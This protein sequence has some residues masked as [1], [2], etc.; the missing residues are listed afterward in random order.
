M[1]A[2]MYSY[3]LQQ[4]L[5]QQLQ[6]IVVGIDEA[7][8]GP[9]LGSLIYTA[10]FWPQSED[11]AISK[12]AF[13]DSKQLTEEQREKLFHSISTHGSIGWV[14]EELTSERISQVISF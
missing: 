2:Y 6:Q 14:I 13:N 10:C 12:L 9:V 8:R 11:E 4:Q 5:Q 3:K 7:G 1:Y